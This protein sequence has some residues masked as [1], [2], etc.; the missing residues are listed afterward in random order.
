MAIIIRIIIRSIVAVIP[1]A[2]AG[3]SGSDH[4]S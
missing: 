3:S 4:R 1:C 2:I